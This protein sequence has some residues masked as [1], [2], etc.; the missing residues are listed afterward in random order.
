MNS[1]KIEEDAFPAKRYLRKALKREAM[2]RASFARFASHVGAWGRQRLFVAPT[3]GMVGV[4][5][6]LALYSS[7][8]ERSDCAVAVN[9]RNCAVRVITTEELPHGAI[10]LFT[11]TAHPQLAEQIASELGVGLSGCTTSTFKNG[12][13]GILVHESVRDCDVFIVQPT[14]NPKPNDYLMELLIMMDAMRYFYDNRCAAARD[15]AAMA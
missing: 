10:R 8:E 12:E 14:C 5:A 11:G 13:T 7:R 15:A 1:F 6:L 4:G 2:F 9:P 3:A